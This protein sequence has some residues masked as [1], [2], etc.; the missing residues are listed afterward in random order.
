[1]AVFVASDGGASPGQLLIALSLSRIPI[2]VYQSVQALV[3][4]RLAAK[5]SGRHFAEWTRI[6]LVFVGGAVAVALSW[7]TLIVFIGP[8]LTGLV[9]G[10]EFV[11]SSAVLLPVAAGIAILTVAL[12]LSDSILSTGG[13]SAVVSVW[14]VGLAAAALALALAQDPV[15]KA[16]L[17]V[18]LG[19]ASALVTGVIVVRVRL[20]RARSV[21]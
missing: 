7:A 20:R 1:V 14:G 11:V 5:W 2:F 4:P 18:I 9:F 17:P 16:T 8:W 12:V 10:P 21:A 19:S 15:A 3:L 6:L 13:H